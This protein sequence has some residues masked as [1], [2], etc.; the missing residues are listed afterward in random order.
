MNAALGLTARWTELRRINEQLRYVNSPH[1]FNVVP[2]GRRSGKTELAKRKLV[3]RALLP[4]GYPGGS[5]FD[6][7]HYFCAAP[8]RDQA[9]RIYWNDI[10]RMIPRELIKRNG[11]SETELTVMTVM[12]TSI[13]VIGMDKPERIEGSPWDGGI[14]D[15]YGNMKAHAWGANIRPALA[16]RNGWCDLIGVPEGRNHYY[17]MA[18]KAKASML[19]R[20]RDSEWGFF[21][22]KSS[23]IL[24]ESEIRA[25]RENLDQLTFEQ[26]YEGSFINFHGRAYYTYT[27]ANKASLEIDPKGDLAFCFDFNVEPGVC[28]VCQ[29]GL[30]PNGLVG[31]KVIGQVYIPQNSNTVAVCKRLVLDWHRP[32]YTGDVYIYG[33]AT[34]GNR[35]SAKVAGSDWDL[36]LEVLRPV[37]GERLKMRV[38]R[39]NPPE[40]ARVNSVNSR[41][42]SATGD[43]RL[44]VD[45]M[46]AQ[47][48]NRD[49]DGVR[50]LEG[51][52]GELDK[53]SDKR[54]TH[55]SDALGY[56][57]YYCFSGGDGMYIAKTRFG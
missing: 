47:D 20:G 19:E 5:I 46:K 40:R 14:L 17:E 16:D 34:G 2:A 4:K 56:Y 10:K 1:R 39:A 22:W 50:L 33:D 44:F 36:V 24:P 52:S 25:A 9:K 55:I 32:E 42:M 28:A 30:L 51:G 18:E 13:S 27:D 15:E 8:T 26:E 3:M 53:V 6:D 41:C 23:L 37:Y 29:E 38:Q 11:T 21:H 7:P 48:V 12:N 31:T 54:L 35:G 45:L 43:R 49:L 57:I